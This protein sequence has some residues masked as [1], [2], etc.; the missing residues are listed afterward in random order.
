[1]NMKTLVIKECGNIKMDSIYE[2]D[3]GKTD[4]RNCL[5]CW[6]CWLKTPGRC[7]HKDLN[8]FYS[9][10]LE[11]DRVVIFAEVKKGFISGNMKTLLDR[12]IPLYLPYIEPA[13]SGCNHVPRYD[14]YPDIEF[15]YEGTFN[16]VSGREVLEDFI[17]RAFTQ[18]RSRNI[19]IR[20]MKEY[21]EESK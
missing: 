19:T 10:Y 8:D 7:V 16:T 21:R 12:M 17:K 3:L 1:M 9:K 6:N 18:F 13:E 5:G 11:S 14:K 2:L 4:I 15:Y 20:E